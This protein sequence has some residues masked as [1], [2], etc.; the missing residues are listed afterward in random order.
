MAT[1]R[2]P[3]LTSRR[4]PQQVRSADLVAVILQAASQVLASAGAQRFTTARV[5]ERAGVS[6][7]SVYQYFPNKAAILFRL[8]SDEWTRTAETLCAILTDSAQSSDARLRAWV[9]AFIASECEE[10]AVRAALNEAAP[11][12][13]ETP[14]SGQSRESIGHALE[15]FMAGALPHAAAD[16]RRRIGDLL[17]S[18]LNA[19]GKQFSMRPR[20]PAQIREHADSLSEMF[21]AYLHAM[22]VR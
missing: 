10:A 15:T 3:Q 18:T 22:N 9:H 11:R 8:Q 4:Q 20:T 14:G 17:R 1:R 7:G 12:Y 5:A 21:S 2:L 16:T 6:V 19:A 13:R